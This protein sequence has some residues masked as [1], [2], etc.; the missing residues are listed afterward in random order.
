MDY[1]LND[2]YGFCLLTRLRVG[3]SHLNEHKFRHNFLDTLDP[4]CA[5]RTDSIENTKHYLLQCPNYSIHRSKL[6]EDLHN[7][8][9]SVLPYACDILIDIL[10]YG[11][12]SLSKVVNR[13]I[14]T[15]TINY[16]DSTRR[17]GIPLFN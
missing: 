4:F 16:I 3:F 10:L 8:H 13:D 5:C 6:F 14:L 17:F 7:I 9:I 11:N 1:G 15:A 12:S 2:N